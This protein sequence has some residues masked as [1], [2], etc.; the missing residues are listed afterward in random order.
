MPDKSP[1]QQFEEQRPRLAIS[2]QYLARDDNP[3]LIVKGVINI[4]MSARVKA[5]ARG[6]LTRVSPHKSDQ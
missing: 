6:V 2:Q 4:G 1:E 5:A 3:D